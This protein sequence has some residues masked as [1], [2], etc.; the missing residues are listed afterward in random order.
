MNIK[1]IIDVLQIG[2]HIG[3]C[4]DL[5]Y[6]INFR[7][8][9]II[10]IEPVPHLFKKLQSN[11]EHKSKENNI[12]FLNIAV[13]NKDG[14][15]K[16]YT[17]SLNNNF[18]LL[19]IWVDQI[20]SVNENHIKSHIKKEIMV[21]E[22]KVPC[23]RLNTIISFYNIEHIEYLIVDTEGHDF[24]ILM[25]LNFNVIKPVNIIFENAH[26]DGFLSKNHRYNLLMT[27]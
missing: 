27:H 25:D 26:I 5:I 21:D 18:T 22:I 24:E 15:I 2:S 3:T 23:K 8:N 10:L 16:F 4:N 12:I 1:M 9:N 11:Y 19:P 17:P 13:S 6:N 7:N 20:S 14:F